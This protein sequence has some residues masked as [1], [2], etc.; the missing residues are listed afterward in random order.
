MKMEVM[1]S[2]E[3][4]VQ[5]RTTRRYISEDGNFHIYSCENLKSYKPKKALLIP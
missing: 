2:S 5:I 3:T 4:S 1:P